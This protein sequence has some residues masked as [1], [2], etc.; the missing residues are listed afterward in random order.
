MKVKVGY[1][2][3]WRRAIFFVL[4]MCIVVFGLSSTVCARFIPTPVISNIV[5]VGVLLVCIALFI[6]VLSDKW[7]R[8]EGEGIAAIEDGTFTYHDKKRH[9][10]VALIDIKNV[11]MKPITLGQTSQTILAYQLL[12]QMNHGKKKYVI[13]SERARGQAY[14]EVDLHRL[15]IWLQ[16]KRT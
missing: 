1:I 3:S 16:E 15:Y 6:L 12:I 11:D 4:V 7:A 13:E 9:I 8:Y 2:T 14:N 5:S 10:Q